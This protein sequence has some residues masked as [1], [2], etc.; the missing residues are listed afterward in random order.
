MLGLGS[1]GVVFSL[2][3]GYAAAPP[4]PVLSTYD[5]IATWPH[6]PEAFTQGLSFVNGRLFE[7]TGL[8]GHSALREV[9]LK[10]G[11]V[12]R[13]VRLNEKYFG[14]GTTILNGKAY[15]LT[16]KNQTGF[17][18]NL[19]TFKVE[20]EFSYPSEGWGLTTDG[21]SL[22]LSD[23]TD[24]IRFLDPETFAVRRTIHVANQGTPIKNL[25]E[26]E[27]IKGEIYANVWQTN[28]IIRID[29]DTGALLGV[30]NLSRLLARE[31]YT[32]STDVLNGIAYDA[33]ADR[34]FVTG[35]KWPKLFEIRLRPSPPK[36]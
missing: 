34:L 7:G 35:K 19:E 2:A 13:E 21:K 15:Q 32:P 23:G 26:L 20:K 27:Y 29:P 14:E 3:T 31:D 16:W 5:V 9:D 36:S 12:V 24:E 17:V 10:S 6:D 30:I 28:W 8:N 11:R 4:E 1:S 33:E 22:I 18:Y 25:N